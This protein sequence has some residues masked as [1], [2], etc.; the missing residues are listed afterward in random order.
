MPQTDEELVFCV[1]D[2]TLLELITRR[3]EIVPY[4][5]VLIAALA[6]GNAESGA[7]GKPTA[8]GVHAPK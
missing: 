2:L 4:V 8:C 3:A 1:G 6:A 5:V 7:T